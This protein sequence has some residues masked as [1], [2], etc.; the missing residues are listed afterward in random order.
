VD[1]A[2]WKLFIKLLFPYGRKKL[3]PKNGTLASYVLYLKNEISW[4]VR[5]TETLL[6]IAY[7]VLSCIIRLR[8]G[9]S[10]VEQIFII[11]QLMEKCFE[12][13][14]IFTYY[15]LIIKKPL[16]SLIEQSS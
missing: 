12:F 9:R 7:K 2:P 13:S 14:M 6:S 11:H 3:G 4:S 15:L 16:I 10:T 5:I 8:H 1:R